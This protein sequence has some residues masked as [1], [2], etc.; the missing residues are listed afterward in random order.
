MSSSIAPHL[1]ARDRVSHWTRSFPLSHTC[2]HS[3]QLGYQYPRATQPFMWVLGIW[4]Q[5]LML[6]GTSVLTHWDI[7]PA[8][9]ITFEDYLMIMEMFNIKWGKTLL[10][11]VVFTMHSPVGFLC[12]HLSLLKMWSN[13]AGNRWRVHGSQSPSAG[14]RLSFLRLDGSTV[15]IPLAGP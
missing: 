2:L 10:C 13:D 14:S 1:T 3:T 12:L 7:F 8:S 5:A 11:W 6:T 4:T 15:E 9:E